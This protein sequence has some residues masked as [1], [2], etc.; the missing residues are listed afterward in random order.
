[1]AANCAGADHADGLLGDR[2][3]QRDDVGLGE[4]LVE[5]VAGLVVVRVVGDD[6]DAQP[7]QA[8]SQRPGDGAETDQPG[9]LPRH[10]PRPEPLVG[11]RAVAKHL[12]LPHIRV[13]GQQVAGGREK[14]GERHF[15]DGVGVAAGGVEHRDARARWRRRRRRCS[16]RRGSRRWPEAAGR[17]PGR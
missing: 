2:R 4:Q 15:G 3:V 11:D 14:Q 9:R 16:G 17:T 7:L 6:L 8:P 5:A 1:M 10:L 12:A 13:G